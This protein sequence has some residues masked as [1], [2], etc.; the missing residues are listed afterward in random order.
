MRLG[1]FQV[2]S[3]LGLLGGVLT[4]LIA[5]AFFLA[6][7]RK[8]EDI[9]A[10]FNL[11]AGI[12]GVRFSLRTWDDRWLRSV[13]GQFW[14]ASFPF[15]VGLFGVVEG[16]GNLGPFG[17]RLLVVRLVASTLLLAGGAWTI[18]SER[19]RTQ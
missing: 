15:A 4:C 19:Q 10:W 11:L 8:W 12:G 9:F 3:P 7:D 1:R 18:V 13:L 17:S 16:L 6:A 2:V 5:V 14:A